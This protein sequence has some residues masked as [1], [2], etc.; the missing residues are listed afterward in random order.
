M[1]IHAALSNH[2]FNSSLAHVAAGV[3]ETIF[4]IAA[5][6][7]SCNVLKLNPPHKAYF[8]YIQKYVCAGGMMWV[9]FER[10]IP[11]VA[12]KTWFDI[13]WHYIQYHNDKGRFW[14]DENLIFRPHRQA[15]NVAN[16]DNI[17]RVTPALYFIENLHHLLTLCHIMNIHGI[18]WTISSMWKPSTLLNHVH[19]GNAS[20]AHNALWT[21]TII[22]IWRLMKGCYFRKWHLSQA[23]EI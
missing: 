19:V 8:R 21:R 13:S 5:G 10:H 23:G 17:G 9:C 11:A 1:I 20:H 18:D 7:E 6:S 15:L 22:S 16:C 12:V 2:G 14:T 4:M 3:F